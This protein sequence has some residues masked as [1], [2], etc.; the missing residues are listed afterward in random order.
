MYLGRNNPRHQYSLGAIL[1]ENSSVEKGL[2]VLVDN[3]LSMSQESL[4]PRWPVVSWGALER[5][6]TAG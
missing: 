6:L 1:L 3:R 4:W 5:A 2:G